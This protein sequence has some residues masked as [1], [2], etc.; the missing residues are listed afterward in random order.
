MA[1]NKPK[2]QTQAVAKVDDGTNYI[3]TGYQ[4]PKNLRRLNL[5]RLVKMDQVPVDAT[6]VGRL[7]KIQDN[8]TGKA[9]MR[10]AKLLWLK[11]N[12]GTE[13]EVEFLFPMS[14]VIRKALEPKPEE[15]VGKTLYITRRPDGVSGKFKKA[16]F[17]FDVLVDD[18][19]AKK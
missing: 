14:G 19:P 5:P 6:I 13:R 16:M 2:T 10:E 3:L 17:I 11:S 4:A 18:S 8:I 9:E 12:E 7:V 15:Y 1:N